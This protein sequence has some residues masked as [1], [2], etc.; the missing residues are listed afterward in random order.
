MITEY[1]FLLVFGIYMILN[2]IDDLKTHTTKN[3]YHYPMAALLIVVASLNGIVI[4]TFLI[5][6]YALA[7]FIIYSKLPI[8]QFGAG[9]TKMLVNVY[10]FLNLISPFETAKLFF[11]ISIVYLVVSYFFEMIIRFKKRDYGGKEVHAEAPAIFIT[12]ALLVSL[13]MI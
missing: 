9:D 6:M 2:V 10:M 7:F 1:L 5:G 13:F 11:V 8:I 4:S 12:F 3:V